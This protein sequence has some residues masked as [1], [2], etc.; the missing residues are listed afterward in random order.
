M[1]LLWAMEAAF[2]HIRL[3]SCEASWAQAD[4]LS[5]DVICFNAAISACV[6]SQAFSQPWSLFAHQL[7]PELQTSVHATEDLVEALLRTVV[8]GSQVDTV[9]RP[10]INRVGHP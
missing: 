4:K 5:P 7:V 1:Q 9:Q 6:R 8:G 10:S 2:V 3:H